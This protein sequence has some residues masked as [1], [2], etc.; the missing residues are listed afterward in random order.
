MTKEKELG[1]LVKTEISKD[2]FEPT[3][4]KFGNIFISFI[5]IDK[6]DGKPRNLLNSDFDNKKAHEYYADLWI[7]CQM[8]AD[9]KRPETYAW[10]VEYYPHIVNK[11]EAKK[12]AKTLE[13]INRR[14]KN[15]CMKIGWPESFGAFVA[16]IANLTKIKKVLFVSEGNKSRWYSD[17]EYR[18]LP[19]DIAQNKIN[20]MAQEMINSLINQAEAA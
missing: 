13:S 8:E 6:N 2:I 17:N 19:V 12:M 11:Y 7:T 20:E 15:Q 18:T 3:K 1:L 14:Y 10:H 9:S 5:G 16:R 4:D